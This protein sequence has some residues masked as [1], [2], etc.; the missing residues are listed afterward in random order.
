MSQSNSS[1]RDKE[2]MTEIHTD[3]EQGRAPACGQA[4]MRQG[5]MQTSAD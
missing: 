3:Q 1:E 5:V 2:E 4:G